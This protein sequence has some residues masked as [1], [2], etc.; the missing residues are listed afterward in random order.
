MGKFLCPPR[1]RTPSPPPPRQAS[2]A[3]YVYHYPV[4]GWSLHSRGVGHHMD[5]TRQDKIRTSPWSEQVSLTPFVIKL[6]F[7]WGE[8]KLWRLTTLHC[9]WLPSS[10]RETHHQCDRIKTKSAANRVIA[11]FHQ[12]CDSLTIRSCLRSKQ[13]HVNS[14][15][16]LSLTKKIF[17]GAAA[18]DFF[19]YT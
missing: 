2:I 1:T 6:N 5:K 4:P 15:D 13:T 14:Y 18:K 17:C 9:H 3:Y 8:L 19:C 16:M 12:Q 11:K 10:D 7:N